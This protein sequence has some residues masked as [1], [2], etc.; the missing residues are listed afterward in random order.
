MFDIGKFLERLRAR[1]YDEVRYR[2][3]K[4]YEEHIFTAYLG[5]LHASYALTDEFARGIRETSASQIIDRLDAELW[6]KLSAAREA[7]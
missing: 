4:K 6:E 3:N 7:G 2:W 5:D 1:P